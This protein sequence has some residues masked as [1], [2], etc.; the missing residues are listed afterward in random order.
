MNKQERLEILKE[1]TACEA[2][3]E[4]LKAKLNERED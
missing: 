1:A 2:H 4:R 3:L